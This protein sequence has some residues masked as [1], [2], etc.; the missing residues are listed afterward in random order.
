MPILASSLFS[1]FFFNNQVEVN[2]LQK[3][4][5]NLRIEPFSSSGNPPTFSALGALGP[6]K[7]QQYYCTI[8]LLS[9]NFFAIITVKMFPFSG[10]NVHALFTLSVFIYISTNRVFSFLS[11]VSPGHNHIWILDE[12]INNGFWCRHR[13]NVFVTLI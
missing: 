6:L 5:E 4:G 7:K 12:V 2:Q 8:V 11:F 9:Y 1:I 10:V 13:E 3:A